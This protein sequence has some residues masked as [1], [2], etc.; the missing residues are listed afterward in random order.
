MENSKL[1]SITD[2]FYNIYNNYLNLCAC[3]SYPFKSTLDAIST[4]IYMIPTEGN[5]NNRFFP[6]IKYIDDIEIESEK[7][8]L[9]LFK[10]TSDQYSANIQP[11]SGTQ[12]N[13]IVYNAILNDNDTVLAL[14]PKDGGHISHTKLAGK[15]NS[16]KYYKLNSQLDIDLLKLEQLLCKHKPKLVIVGTSSYSKSFPFKVISELVHKY[17]AYLLA[18]ICHYTLF[19]LGQTIE[20]CVPY[21]DFI[22][23]TMDKLLRGPQG[24]IILYKKQFEKE[25]KYSVFPLSQGGPLQSSLLSKYACLVELSKINLKQY[26]LQVNQNAKLLADTLSNFGV[27]IVSKDIDNH[28]ILINTM[29][30]GKSGKEAEKL[31]FEYNIL[32]NKNQ[33]PSDT[34]S[35]KDPSGIRIGSTCLTNLNFSRENIIFLGKYIASILLE[36]VVEKEKFLQILHKYLTFNISNVETTQA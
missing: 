28:I 18:D 21:A 14:S 8:L 11:H 32:V 15:S 3:C 29:L 20:S 24:G 19:I 31:L 35:I 16:V 17:G 6:A 12:A 5:V 4:P 30:I 34:K 22:T 25:I 7:I 26:A 10:T 2:A 1:N 9:N 13:Q 27:P 23:F 36:K 33:I